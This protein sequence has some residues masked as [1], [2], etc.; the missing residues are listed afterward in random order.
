M[1]P[2][3][4]STDQSLEEPLGVKT[5]QTEEWFH[6]CFHECCYHQGILEQDRFH[7]KKMI[8]LWFRKRPDQR[9]AGMSMVFCMI[10]RAVK[11]MVAR[12]VSGSGR[13][14]ITTW[15]KPSLHLDL[16]SNRHSVSK[17]G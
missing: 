15:H 4:L 9:V 7:E 6:L 3:H 1:I 2:S 17:V 16:H 10:G 11:T 13:R 8:I 14:Q 5:Q 12:L